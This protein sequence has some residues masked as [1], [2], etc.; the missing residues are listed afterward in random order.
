MI[1]GM[2]GILSFSMTFSFYVILI[3]KIIEVLD[4]FDEFTDG[5]YYF[6]SKRLKNPLILSMTMDPY[7]QV[8]YIDV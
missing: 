1:N 4:L 5:S 6:A 8:Y 7:G 3:L 2:L